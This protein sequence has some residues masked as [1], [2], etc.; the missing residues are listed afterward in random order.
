MKKQVDASSYTIS[1]GTT[2]RPLNAASTG[3]TMTMAACNLAKLPNLLASVTNRATQIPRPT[4]TPQ[5]V[6]F[7]S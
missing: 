2:R 5:R 3:L 1:R 7:K 6:A 4:R